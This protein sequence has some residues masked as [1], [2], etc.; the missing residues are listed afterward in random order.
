M[1]GRA[2]RHP[3]LPAVAAAALLL[4]CA[5]ARPVV[6]LG[7]LQQNDFQIFEGDSLV[8]T[9]HVDRYADRMEGAIELIGRARAEYV[10][11]LGDSARIR[12]IEAQVRPWQGTSFGNAV[13]VDFRGDSVVT[14]RRLPIPS[15]ERRAVGPVMPYM[16]PSPALIQQIVWRA[17]QLG[18]PDS[19]ITIWFPTRSISMPVRV[20]RVSTRIADV[21]I[22]GGKIRVWLDQF[23]LLMAEVPALGWLIQRR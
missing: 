4:G 22:A 6:P 5:S 15:T 10:A 7:P 12:R 14:E 11:F 2:L 8:A 18:D 13:A 1:S 3:A 20:H 9:E 16:H 21:E 19:E 23:G 17:L